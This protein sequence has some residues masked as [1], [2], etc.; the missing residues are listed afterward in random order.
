MKPNAPNVTI[1]DAD[2]VSMGAF[3]DLQ[4]GLGRFD[5]WGRFAVH[6][7][8]QRFRRS[9]LGPFWITL[10]LGIMV[11][12]LGL[13][14]STLFQQDMRQIL[15]HIATGLIFWGLLTGC[16]GDGTTV[17]IGSESYIRNVPLPLSVHVYR[18]LARNVII[19]AFNMAIY[20]GILLVFKINPGWQVL[21]VIPGLVLFA[22]NMSWMALA[23]GIL[24]TRYRDIPQVIMNAIQVIFFVTPVFWSVESLPNR[25]AFVHFN[26]FFHMLEIVR[27]PLLGTNASLE[28]W[29]F[30][31][32]MAVV[33]FGFTAYLYRRAYARIAFWV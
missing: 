31:L 14:F 28:S 18:M 23:A 24:S 25:P 9:V 13:V 11:G 12:A 20:F 32:A 22:L 4:K 7:I 6:D 26:P 1:I 30:V 8:R 15:P 29:L 19:W 17:F 33:G 21:L 10:S 5:I 27:A 2:L 3:Q 16:I